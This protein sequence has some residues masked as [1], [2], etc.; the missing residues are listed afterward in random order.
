MKTNT[1]AVYTL[2]EKDRFGRILYHDCHDMELFKDIECGKSARPD[3]HTVTAVGEPDLP[4][5]RF[6]IIDP[7]TQ[8]K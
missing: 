4:V 1:I 2:G 7:E 5:K 6:V 3:L 8:P